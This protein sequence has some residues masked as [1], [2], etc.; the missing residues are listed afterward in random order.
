MTPAE[1][2]RHLRGD[3]VRFL[4]DEDEPGV[5]WRTLVTLLRRPHD[6]EAVVRARRAARER[7]AAAA[8]L[9][10]QD[11]LGY[12]GSPVAYGVRWSGSAWQLMAAAQLGAD[13]EDPRVER[14]VEALLR[15][16]QPRW[17][18]FSPAHGKMPAACFTAELCA[19][20]ARLGYAHHPRVREALAWLAER[21]GGRGGW[22]CPDLRHLLSGGCAIAATAVLRLVVEHPPEERRNLA[23]L[24]RRAAGW[25]LGN[26]LF[27]AGPAPRGWLSFGSPSLHR[28]D[29]LEALA[30][31][32][33]VGWP[34]EA[35]VAAALQAVLARQDQE[36]RWAQQ[37]RLPAGEAFGAPSR[38]VTLKAL[39]VLEAYGGER[40]EAPAAIGRTGEP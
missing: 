39:I 16:V 2:W 30:G 9:A 36:G 7:G 15:V 31:L 33:S 40:F 24:S 19:V 22:S 14:A 10:G 28:S 20:L 34:Q 4:L 35:T 12:W 37:Q 32:A 26:G 23:A 29:L 25:L 18:G 6:A 13:P 3:P 38:W 17:G 5:V 1:W 11:P 21:D 8:L 27:L